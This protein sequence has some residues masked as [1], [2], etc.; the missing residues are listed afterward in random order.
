VIIALSRA[1][2]H[3]VVRMESCCRDGRLSGLVQEA[4]IGLDARELFALEVEDFDRV[5]AGTAV[6]S[7][8]NGPKGNW[9]MDWGKLTQQILEDVHAY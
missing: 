9:G 6:Q 7:L 1:S 8:V 5:V 3:H 2:Q 4:G